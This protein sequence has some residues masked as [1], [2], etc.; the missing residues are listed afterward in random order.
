MAPAKTGSES[1]SR[2]VVMKID[3]TKRGTW[4]MDI[5]GLRIFRTVEIKLMA[6]KMEEAPARCKEKIAKSTAPP[7]WAEQPARGG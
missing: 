2:M 5:P 6:P 4:S 3:Q 1:R 7:L